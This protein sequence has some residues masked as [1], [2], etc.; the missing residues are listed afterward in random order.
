MT[1]QTYSNAE[2]ASSI[3]AEYLFLCYRG[4]SIISYAGARQG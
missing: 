2:D 4:F 3:D 1:L